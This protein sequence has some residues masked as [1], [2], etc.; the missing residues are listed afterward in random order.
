MTSLGPLTGT[1]THNAELLFDEV[2]TRQIFKF[3]C[4][5]LGG[6]IDNALI[7][8]KERRLAQ[9]AMIRALDLTFVTQKPGPTQPSA[10]A[11]TVPLRSVFKKLENGHS[12]F[13]WRHAKHT[14]LRNAQIS[15]T[16]FNEVSNALCSE[17]DDDRAEV[18][19]LQKRYPP[20]TSTPIVKRSLCDAMMEL[21]KTAKSNPLLNGTPFNKD[22]LGGEVAVKGS[23]SPYEDHF[24]D[25]RNNLEYDIQYIQVGWPRWPPQ[26]AP[27]MAGQTAP[28]RTTGLS[29]FLSFA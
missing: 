7:R 28:G 2:E 16:A 19:R 22:M 15:T 18:A 17:I 8:N 29:V 3:F 6:E 13:W 4:P 25:A 26:T 21:A 10:V 9:M 20:I 12:K 23:G 11:V 14:D 24:T 5:K 1:S 27:L